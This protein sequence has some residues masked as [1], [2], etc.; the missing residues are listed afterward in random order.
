MPERESLFSTDYAITKIS[1]TPTMPYLLLPTLWNKYK[2]GSSIRLA[3]MILVVRWY[4]AQKITFKKK[5]T[6]ID[7]ETV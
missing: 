2:S 7:I 5:K 4:H 3:F 6:A 1:V